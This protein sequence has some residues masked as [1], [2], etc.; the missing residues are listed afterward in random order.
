MWIGIKEKD[1]DWKEK[2]KMWTGKCKKKGCQQTQTK[3]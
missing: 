3:I 2:R 1:V